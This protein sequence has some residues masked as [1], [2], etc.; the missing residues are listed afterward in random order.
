[1]NVELPFS[2]YLKHLKQDV[3][4]KQTKH[5]VTETPNPAFFCAALR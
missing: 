1:M 3:L 2:G 5:A 4:L